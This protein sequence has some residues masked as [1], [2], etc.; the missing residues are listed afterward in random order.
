[1]KSGIYLIKNKINNHSYVGMSKD[2][3]NRWKHHCHESNNPN[4]K[5]YQKTLY[6]AFRKYGI[7]NF[8][9]IVLE[10]CDEKQLREKEIYWI[11][12]LNT[13][14]NGYNEL[15]SW[16]PEIATNGEN[17]PNHKL[18]EDD[19]RDIRTRYNNH[20]R[21]KDV[22]A[23]YKEKIGHSG[24]S[25]IWRG[26]TWK[27]IMP[28]VYTNEN[29]EF[30]LHNTGNKGESNGRAKFTTEE[31]TIIRLRKKNGE[32]MEDVYLDYHH[33]CKLKYFQEIW[34]NYKWKNVIV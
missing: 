7:N 33:L 12:K 16:Q 22:E 8:E 4:S 2:I 5:E 18:T 21:R 25:K 26:E 23:L 32:R 28:E 17:H 20:E 27:D 10:Y 13:I 3:K 29:K 9:F 34:Y 24:F 6:R 15:N 19:I 30:H 1:M 14:D 31:I 11:N